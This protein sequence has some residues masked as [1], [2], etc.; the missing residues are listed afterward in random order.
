MGAKMSKLITQS[1]INLEINKQQ[2]LISHVEIANQTTVEEI[3][4]KELIE[5]YIIQLEQ[6][7]GKVRF[8]TVPYGKTKQ[9]KKTLVAFHCNANTIYKL[10]KQASNGSAW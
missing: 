1:N 3:N 6:V 9:L 7:G 2:A 10:V 5:K 4:T 8:E